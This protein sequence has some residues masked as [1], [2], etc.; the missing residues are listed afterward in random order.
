[1]IKKAVRLIT[2]AESTIL[3]NTLMKYPIKRNLGD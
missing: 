2:Y 1:M 3:T